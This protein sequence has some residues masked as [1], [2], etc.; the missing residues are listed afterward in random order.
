MIIEGH[1]TRCRGLHAAMLYSQTILKSIIT[2]NDLIR[3]FVTSDIKGKYLGSFV[4]FWGA[5]I[6]PLL[7]LVSYCFVFSG[8]LKIKFGI[9]ESTAGFAVY[10]FCGLIPW[11]GFSETVQRSATVMLDQRTL[12]KRVPLPKEILPFY[13]TVSTFISQL[14]ALIVFIIILFF[15]GTHLGSVALLLPLIFPFQI[16][17]TFGFALGTA[18]LQIFYKDI[19]VFLGSLLQIWF[20]CTPVFYPESLIPKRF[21]GFMELNPFFHLVHIYRK[22]LLQ[23]S[24]PESSSVAY[25]VVAS[26]VVF[27]IGCGIFKKFKN[28]IVD[29]L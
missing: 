6:N 9:S 29:Y 5:V 28:K 3:T 13:I 21:L 10:L 26:F 14:I 24:L 12:I 20:F 23:D 18:S 19:G 1:V 8:I 4:G 7:L 15:L 25:F 27:L 11:M 22:V 2:H 16:L 17:F